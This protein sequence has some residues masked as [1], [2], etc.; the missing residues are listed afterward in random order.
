MIDHED[1][2]YLLL[3]GLASVLIYFYLLPD[4]VDLHELALQNQASISK[5]HM[6]GESPVY[7]S[8]VAPHGRSL[9]NG[10]A[11]ASGQ[12]AGTR[13]GNL[14]DIWKLGI[15]QSSRQSNSKVATLHS[16]LTGSVSVDPIASSV[17]VE[18]VYHLGQ[19]L[20]TLRGDST[21]T[22]VALALPNCQQAFTTLFAATL[23]NIPVTF[24][25]VDRYSYQN[26][27][28]HIQAANP[29]AL[30]IADDLVLKDLEGLDLKSLNKIV[31][32]REKTEPGTVGWKE[33]ISEFE[34]NSIGKFPEI[35]ESETSFP[36]QV[37]F[38]RHGKVEVSKFTHQ[39]LAAAVASHIKVLPNSKQ[40]TS[41]DQVLI[42]TSQLTVFTVVSQ[43]AALVCQSNLIFLSKMNVIPRQMLHAA[44]PTIIVTDDETT[45]SLLE[46]K[47]DLTAMYTIKQ[48]ISE[49]KLSRGT[50]PSSPVLPEFASVRLIYSSTQALDNQA[51]E[52]P[53]PPEAEKEHLDSDDTNAIRALTGA[54][55]VHCLTSP[56]V[57]GAVAS[58]NMYDY[59]LDIAQNEAWLTNYGPVAAN[60]EAVLHDDPAGSTEKS[61]E[62]RLSVR[63]FSKTGQATEWIDLGIQAKF[64]PDGCL[65]LKN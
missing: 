51:S 56:F 33:L 44:K 53:P 42:F 38:E 65:K 10:L 35:D 4:N 39:N 40:W 46:Q 62:G 20:L 37:T 12:G 61:N 32:I 45:F 52:L 31:T 24:L 22:T 57:A 28:E 11:V 3:I 41:S 47:Y 48:R 63:G 23:V 8:L 5:V 34:G 36:V 59:R 50:L 29:F 49:V 30:L 14:A 6:E 19:W 9:I 16:H 26:L 64:G 7:R 25:P 17:L 15:V 1:I 55:F 60:L 2:F 18:Q 43:L 21:D 54:R 13:P 27:S 58:T